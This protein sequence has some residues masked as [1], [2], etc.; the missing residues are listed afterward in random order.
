MWLRAASAALWLVLP[1]G[2]TPG[3]A[4]TTAQNDAAPV[5]IKIAFAGDSIVDNYWSG[6]SR[7][8]DGN[9]CLKSNVELGRFAHNGTGLT[10]GD[11]VYWPR[12]IKRIDDTFK[13]T[14][15]VLSYQAFTPAQ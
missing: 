9:A 5:K 12:E 6:V 1:L 13:P 4:A 3:M 15:S 2:A 7:I 10:R 14:L 8:I 11:R